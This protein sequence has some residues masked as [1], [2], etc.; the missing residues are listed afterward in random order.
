MM[1]KTALVCVFALALAA[2]DKPKQTDSGNASKAEPTA[3]SAVVGENT[4]PTVIPPAPPPQ[5]VPPPVRHN[6]SLNQGGTYGYEPALSEDDIRSGTATKPLVMMRYVGQ[7]NGNYILLILDQNNENVATRITC[8]APCDFAQ[9][10]IT[11]NGVVLRTETLRVTPNSLLGAMVEDAVAGQLIPYGY[12]A[13][14]APMSGAAPTAIQGTQPVADG[15]A[16]QQTS[17]DCAKARSIPEYLICHDPD[18]AAADRELAALFQQAKAAAQDR[19]AFT[20]R[21]RKQWNYREKN[22]TD[23]ACLMAWYAYQTNV[24]TKIAQTGDVNAN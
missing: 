12:R 18:L 14:I 21:T 6:F 24:L 19:V 20:E 17:F 7:R 13:P 9:S 1:K 23:K 8:Q 22:C 10:Q 11:S 4:Q 15:E 2:C 3:A 5:P 16:L